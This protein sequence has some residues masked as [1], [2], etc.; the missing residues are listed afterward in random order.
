MGEMHKDKDSY[1]LLKMGGM[2]I[3]MIGR[4]AGSSD[5][6]VVH[7]TVEHN[8]TPT[9]ESNIAYEEAFA[10]GFMSGLMMDY[11]LNLSMAMGINVEKRGRGDE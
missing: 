3:A 10:G 7:F 4:E 1:V 11:P 8:Y 9:F 6:D 2:G 5:V